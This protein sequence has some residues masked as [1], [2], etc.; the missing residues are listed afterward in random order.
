MADVW[1][2]LG[3]HWYY[4]A[5][6]AGIAVLLYRETRRPQKAAAKWLFYGFYPL[7]L[8][9]LDICNVVMRL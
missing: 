3:S 9:V 4:L 5:S 2:W 1:N 6:A 7:H 8:L